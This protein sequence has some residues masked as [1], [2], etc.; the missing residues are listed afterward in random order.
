M[1]SSVNGFDSRLSFS[2]SS[3]CNMTVSVQAGFGT[4]KNSSAT[5][6]GPA[7]IYIDQSYANVVYPV[8]KYQSSLG[9]HSLLI[10]DQIYKGYGN[11]ILFCFFP[12]KYIYPA[13]S[14]N[15]MSID[16]LLQ[17]TT[18]SRQ[19]LQGYSTIS[20]TPQGNFINSPIICDR[21]F[22]QNGL[23]AE[24]A[25][26]K[27]LGTTSCN[28]LSSM[29]GFPYL[30]NWRVASGITYSGTTATTLSK[31]TYNFGQ[32]CSVKY[33]IG[34]QANKQS[35]PL[36]KYIRA[37]NNVALY[38]V[39]KLK[40]NS[41][42]YR[43]Y[44]LVNWNLQHPQS[45]EQNS[46][47]QPIS[48]LSQQSTE[49]YSKT[50]FFFLV[51]LARRSIG[52]V[53]LQF[54]TNQC[55]IKAKFFKHKNQFWVGNTGSQ[56]DLSF[57]NRN[58]PYLPY[59]MNN[60]KF[61]NAR[62]MIIY[63]TYLGIS[64]QPGIQLGGKGT[65][66][67]DGHKVRQNLGAFIRFGGTDTSKKRYQRK[68]PTFQDWV[69]YHKDSI[70]TNGLTSIYAQSWK[71]MWDNGTATPLSLK[72]ENATASFFFAPLF[73]L[74][75]AKFRVY[76]KGIKAGQYKKD[77]VVPNSA[78]GNSSTTCTASTVSQYTY[79]SGAGE[80][81]STDGAEAIQ[82]TY[83]GSVLFS[84][85]Y[86][87]GYDTSDSMTAD[88]HKHLTKIR[89]YITC[90]N[91]AYRMPPFYDGKDKDQENL[92]FFSEYSMDAYYLQFNIDLSPLLS[93]K[94]KQL[95]RLPIQI[96]GIL[97]LHKI[98]Q[99]KSLLKNENGD[100]TFTSISDSGEA[101]MVSV[102]PI[103]NQT[104]KNR[105]VDWY[106]CMTNIQITHNE[107]GSTGSITLDKY[108]LMAQQIL[109]KQC[110]GGIKVKIN[111]GNPFVINKTYTNS[112]STY[113]PRKADNLL[114]TGYV[115]KLSTSD[116]SS[117]DTITL[118]LQGIQKKLT[119]L[120]L[121]N[122]PFWD[123]DPLTQILN[124]LSFYANIQVV[125]SPYLDKE[126]IKNN[127]FDGEKQYYEDANGSKQT[128]SVSKLPMAPV[129]SVFSRPAVN[130]KSGTDCLTA[131]K[132]VCFKFCNHRFVLQPD[133][134]AYIYTQNK[135]AMPLPC[136]IGDTAHSYYAA[137][138]PDLILN[139]SVQPLMNNLYNF[140]ITACLQGT[141]QGAKQ[142][143]IGDNLTG[144]KLNKKYQQL[145]S[146]DNQTWAVDIP[147]S[148]VIAM[149][150]QGYLSQKQLK[151]QHDRNK[152]MCRNYWLNLKV[153]I[154]GNVNIWIYDKISLFGVQYYVTQVSHNVDLSAKKFTTQVTLCSCIPPQGNSGS[155]SS[156][157]SVSST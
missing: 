100:F 80:N 111:G 85:E 34:Q 14:S 135:L 57:D 88:E 81:S 10:N 19:Q 24:Q 29:S 41:S 63:P 138:D 82:H 116:S 144:I 75:K 101:S 137:I 107:Q 65:I 71:L 8:D 115:T 151:Q 64:I 97:I 54:G 113:K 30:Y 83:Y 74:P 3:F 150:H 125:T 78:A 141:N 44:Q 136:Q 40:P 53:S 94:A 7:V 18:M 77:S 110:I 140:I 131:F 121:I 20:I 73:F 56:V 120:K 69:S 22:S 12:I 143:G 28:Y 148:K 68:F 36:F 27:N 155:S 92:K 2:G 51:K 17:Y 48:A 130:F 149:K 118:T 109:P 87:M 123:G 127:F 60:R 102:L 98:N 108:A 67:S 139:F 4:N 122:P 145:V 76:F 105:S 42:V 79:R 114:F 62:A 37:Q 43:Q 50:P 6:Y 52:N 133:A 38:G 49:F 61:R 152:M 104:C 90:S 58:P 59:F 32:V 72:M 45:V 46:Q 16:K 154:P 96:I 31:L 1:A 21:I 142:T 93:D 89:N 11:K 35:Y 13:T 47:N 157:I 33:N 25:N 153:S 147:W 23:Y 146:S 128:I 39:Q 91:V 15:D 103:Y 84:H 129:S 55:K 119:Q 117:S 26:N 66:I 5:T 124:W 106:K 9:S 70:S 95:P 134:R 99:L 86:N 126:Y 156:S 112:D 132:D